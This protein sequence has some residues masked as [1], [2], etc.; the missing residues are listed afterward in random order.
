MDCLSK[1]VRFYSSTTILVGRSSRC[2]YG[3]FFFI[4]TAAESTYLPDL[5]TYSKYTVRCSTTRMRRKK[6]TGTHL[7]SFIFSIHACLYVL[8]ISTDRNSKSNRF[9]I[10]LSQSIIDCAESNWL[11]WTFGW[12]NSSKRQ[13][14]KN[15]KWKSKQKKT[16]NNKTELNPQ[17]TNSPGSLAMV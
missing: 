14:T 5:G 9:Y 4:K 16:K 13:K 7:R 15:E 10:A 3:H 8:T 11:T 6:R 1:T 2:N 17:K 12:Y